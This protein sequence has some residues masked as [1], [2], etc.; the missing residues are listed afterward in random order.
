M[1]VTQMGELERREGR[2]RKNEDTSS[3]E[4]SVIRERREEKR[5]EERLTWLPVSYT[6]IVEASS[7][8][9]RK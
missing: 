8:C 2:E 6:R 7:D 9:D 1:K 3:R 5:R 4:S